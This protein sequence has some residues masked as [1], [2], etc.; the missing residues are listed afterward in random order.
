MSQLTLCSRDALAPSGHTKCPS[1][2]HIH[3][4]PRPRLVPRLRAAYMPC[5]SLFLRLGL[6]WKACLTHCCQLGSS[7]GHRTDWPSANG[8]QFPSKAR[9]SK[10]GAGHKPGVPELL[11]QAIHRCGISCVSPRDD[12]SE[13]QTRR[14][15]P[16]GWVLAQLF[17]TYPIPI[18]KPESATGQPI[19]AYIRVPGTRIPDR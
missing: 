6:R 2:S 4:L 14:H 19:Y 11:T 9:R 18:M 8:L 12:K 3:W 16:S 1:T 5:F 7:M 15:E 13:R 17:P 10:E